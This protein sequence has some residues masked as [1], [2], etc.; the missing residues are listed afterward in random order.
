MILRLAS[1][2]KP[3]SPAPT[4]SPADRPARPVWDAIEATQHQDP[5]NCWLVTQPSHAALSGEMAA[6][7]RWPGLQ[8]LDQAVVRAIALHDAGWGLP[9]AEMVRSIRAPAGRGVPVASFISAAP[10]DFLRAWTGS[11]ETAAKVCAAGGY[12][13]SRHF[14]RIA[15]DRAAPADAKKIGDFLAREQQRQQKLLQKLLQKQPLSL[16]ELELL[17]DVLQFCDLLSLYACCGAVDEVEFPQKLP[18][19]PPDKAGP[20]GGSQGTVRLRHQAMG[21]H[22]D[23]S[24]FREEH[25]FSFA[26]LRRRQS[27]NDPG[28]TT[29]TVTIR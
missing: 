19:P 25:R 3:S 6:R 1:P 15:E 24:P 12:I 16:E 27:R 20:A 23:P 28:N 17:V 2:A 10:A 4:E 13:V 5:E 26:G 11:I 29:F 21:I 9:D 18:T 8:S 14:C 22:L 7:L